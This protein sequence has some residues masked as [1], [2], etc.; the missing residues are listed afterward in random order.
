[1]ENSENRTV[2][3]SIYSLN[4]VQLNVQN[5]LHMNN[6]LF[7]QWSD[8]AVHTFHILLLIINWKGLC[9]NP[10]HIFDILKE[11]SLFSTLIINW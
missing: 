3:L 11:I 5:E 2:N 6:W 4:D 7:T 8:Q 10:M 1:M 9:Q